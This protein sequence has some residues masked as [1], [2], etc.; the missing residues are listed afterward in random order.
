MHL[1][2]WGLEAQLSKGKQA[3]QQ[4]GK[5]GPR[6]VLGIRLL[7]QGNM[8]GWQWK[9]FQLANFLAVVPTVKQHDRL[10]MV[11]ILTG[12]LLLYDFNSQAQSDMHLP[13]GLCS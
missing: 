1:E 5:S 9:A 3:S 6:E 7:P 4:G 8:T 13:K 12:Q 10:T 2:A 11:D